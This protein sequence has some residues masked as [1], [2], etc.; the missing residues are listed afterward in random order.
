V[1]SFVW[2]VRDGMRLDLPRQIGLFTYLNSDHWPASYSTIRRL[3]DMHN[4]VFAAYAR[5]NRLPFLDVA[6][7]LPL[8]SNLF[9][10]AIHL[11]YPA[12][13]L[14]AWI[15]FQAMTALLDERIA[16]GR[17]PRPS[18]RSWS[19][20]PAFHQPSPRT[21]TRAAILASCSRSPTP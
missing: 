21:I 5:K 4:R 14:H 2:M 1:S 6:A 16:A 9:S 20:H 12:V 15:V 8:D 13:R 7:A 19:T 3:A 11:Q 10:D 18:L 17:L